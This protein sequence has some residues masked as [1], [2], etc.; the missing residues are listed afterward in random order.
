[1]P[2]KK[3]ASKK[4]AAPKKKGYYSAKKKAA[5]KRSYPRQQNDCFITTAC[6]SYYRLDD[7]CSQLLTLRQFRDNI[8]TKSLQGR[9][10]IKV[11]YQVAPIIVE[12]IESSNDAPALYEMIYSKVNLACDAIFQKD[13]SLATRIYAGVVESLMKQFKVD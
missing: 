2:A 7:N 11:Y 8:L 6:V 1:M 3:K 4:K 12:K 5:R 13:Y 9:N 10:L